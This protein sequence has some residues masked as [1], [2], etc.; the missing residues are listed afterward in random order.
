[1]KRISTLLFILA[2]GYSIS[3]T[4]NNNGG[5]ITAQ[6]GSFTYVNG[7]VLNDNS[8]TLA[9]NGNGTATS[10]ELYVTQDIT[11]NADI[12][13]NGYIRLLGNWFD[14]ATF[15]ST[16]GTVFFEG[17][18]QFLGGT[19]ATQFF[20]LTLDGTGIKTQQVDKFVNGTLD[21]KSLHLNT[22][23]YACYV[24][25]AQTNSVQ[26]T[27]GFVSSANGGYLSRATNSTGTYLYP[28]GSTANT[29][30]NIPGSGTYRYRPIEVIPSN[31]LPNE[32]SVRLANLDA[33][34]ETP[35]GYDRSL[36]DPVICSSN[37]FFYHQI[38]R[39][40]GNSSANI[41]IYFDAV[42]DGNWSDAARWNISTPMWED[43]SSPT[44]VNG[45][46]LSHINVT[47]WNDYNDIPYILTKTGILPPPINTPQTA[48]CSPQTVSLTTPSIQGVN[49]TWF[50]N[51]TAIGNG[52]V[53][54]TSFLNEGCYDITLTADDG[55]CN[56]STSALALVCVEP[57][58]YA[59]FTANPT[60]FEY[61]DET[62]H[63]NNLSEDA[64]TYNWIFGDV[65]TSSQENPTVF[66][67]GIEENMLVTLI[68]S[69]ANGC[70]DTAVMVLPYANLPVYFIPNSFTPDDNEQ[71]QTWKPVFTSGFDPYNFN[72]LIFNRWGEVIWES[73]DATVGWDGTY[74][75]DGLK[76]QDGVYTY[77]I[78]FKS[79]Q[80]D[81]K[82]TVNGHITLI[83]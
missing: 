67:E 21:L 68:A 33:T 22:D 79:P 30:A 37:P 12:Q 28:T 78:R 10:A 74:G 2:T 24:T 71:N 49:F 61:A 48:G 62:I 50:A 26:R 7:S 54:N 8:G 70:V 20:N 9:V 4:L 35:I 11:N 13:A 18:N 14:N 45:A 38:D 69:T 15:S 43:M 31:N 66:F 42:A 6:A 75:K 40:T 64:T 52:S 3:Q 36:G 46:P 19:S 25:N 17:G 73:N 55:S 5:F 23:L 51:G 29:S 1:M 27:T 72:L 56:V 47:N 16:T 76:C 60:S 58:P 83:R 53:L 81:N 32:Y 63:F 59:A 65:A 80:N 41:N 44:L 34:N 39:L 57:T 77:K 82:Y